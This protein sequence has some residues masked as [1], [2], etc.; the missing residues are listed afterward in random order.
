LKK[1]EGNSVEV[2]KADKN[3]SQPAYVSSNLIAKKGVSFGKLQKRPRFLGSWIMAPN[4]MYLTFKRHFLL[5][6]LCGMA[7][8]INHVAVSMNHNAF[9]YNVKMRINYMKDSQHVVQKFASGKAKL[10]YVVC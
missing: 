7:F 4:T 1:Q 9:S 2:Q 10:L 3:S 5:T 6:S 8:D